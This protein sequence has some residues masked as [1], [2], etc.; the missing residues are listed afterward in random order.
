MTPSRRDDSS[1]PPR[2][3]AAPAALLR[4]GRQGSPGRRLV[5]RLPCRTLIGSGGTAQRAGGVSDVSAQSLL[6]LLIA[7]ANARGVSALP[8]LPAG[9]EELDEAASTRPAAAPWQRCGEHSALI[10]R[11]WGLARQSPAPPRQCV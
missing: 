9:P 4:R 3:A 5:G 7:D 1:A 2:T 6:P 8:L 10:P 11:P